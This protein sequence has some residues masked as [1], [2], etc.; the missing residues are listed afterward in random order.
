MTNLATSATAPRRIEWIDALR[1][2]TMILVVFSHVEVHGY[3]MSVSVVNQFFMNFRMPLFFFISGFIA[4]RSGEIWNLSHYRQQMLKKARIQIIPTLFFGMLFAI[5]VYAH[6][7][8]LGTTDSILAFFDS[9]TKLG[10]WFTIVLLLMFVVYYTVSLLTARLKTRH[11]QAV[12]AIIAIVLFLV[13]LEM[14]TALIH[15]APARWFCLYHFMLYFQFFVFGNIF[16][17]YKEQLFHLLGRPN[18]IG[19]TI[20]LFFGLYIAKCFLPQTPFG[21]T[22]AGVNTNRLLTEA[23]RYLGILSLVCTFRHYSDT[24]SSRTRVGR[25]LQ[26][27]G[28]RTLDIYLLHYFFIPTLPMVGLFFDNY[29]NI[30]L[31]LATTLFLALVIIGICLLLSG[32][33]RTSPT[34]AHYLFGVK[35]TPDT[36]KQDKHISN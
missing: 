1:G 12:L 25:S 9:K 16:S 11:R 29:Q 33:I 3:Q 36:N 31:H 7:E 20:L 10:Y 27:I 28:R 8:G 22:F 14:R 5:T 19:A 24:F 26:F 4:Y 17:C 18:V 6:R 35:T 15:S 23:V 2:L 13:S 21:H 30:T 32:F 34:L